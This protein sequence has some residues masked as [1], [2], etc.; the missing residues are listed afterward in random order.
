MASYLVVA[1]RTLGGA[2]LGDRLRELIAAQPAPMF[3]VLVPVTIPVAMDVG[4]AMGGIAVIDVE[5]YGYVERMAQERLGAVLSW[6]HEAGVEATGEVVTGDALAAMEQACRSRRF[7]GIIISSLA[8]RWSRWLRMDLVHRA[9]RKFDIPI[10]TIEGTEADDGLDVLTA[11]V[12]STG[13]P[14]P[15]TTTNPKTNK[16]K[17]VP[18]GE[19]VYKVIELVGT[20][21]ESWEK[22]AAAAVSRASSTLRD[23][24]VAE[25]AMLDMVIDEGRVSAY[26]AKIKVSFKYEDEHD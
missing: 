13:S 4:G 25:I 14:T 2:E 24:R 20:S 17:K 5:N 10:T 8:T 18:V 3:V 26:R 1:N 15:P 23:L 21:T 7:D 9:E 16:T 11:P 19:S 6:L 22:A 12:A